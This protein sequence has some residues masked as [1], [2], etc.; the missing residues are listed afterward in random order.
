MCG[1]PEQVRG[2]LDGAAEVPDRLLGPAQLLEHHAEVVVR[3][4]HLGLELHGTAEV[5][6]RLVA[7]AHSLER[8]AEGIE[9]F[10]IVGT[11]LQCDAAASGR[12][13][14]VAQAAVSFGQVDVKGRDARPQGHGT[15][16]PFDGLYVF[17]AVGVLKA[18]GVQSGS[19][20]GLLIVAIGRC[21]GLTPLDPI[22]HRPVPWARHGDG[23]VPTVC[24]GGS[25]RS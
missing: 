15:A 4:D 3:R 7:A 25:G 12:P 23:G 13:W 10:G 18:T 8:E 20:G 14:T 5:L 9:R 17:A 16:E 24:V 6:D 2:E 19:A 21:G 1:C 11:E 22:T